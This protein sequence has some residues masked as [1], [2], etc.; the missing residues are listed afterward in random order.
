MSNKF[1]LVKTEEDVYPIAQLKKDRTTLWDGVRNYQARNYLKEM[2]I[3]DLVF[4]YH[5]NSKNPG[6]VG[7]AEVSKLAI[8][9][10]LQFIKSS[11]YYDEKATKEKPRWLSP[12]LKFKKAATKPISLVELKENSVMKGSQLVSQGNRLSVIPLTEVQGTYLLSRLK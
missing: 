9:D 3:G 2:S 12:T 7:Y 8:P 5:S 11:D 6:I 10:P 4:I 1:W